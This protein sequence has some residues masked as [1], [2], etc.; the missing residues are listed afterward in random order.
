MILKND[1]WFWED[2]EIFDNAKDYIPSKSA[3]MAADVAY[4]CVKS[5]KQ[6][7]AGEWVWNTAKCTDTASAAVCEIMRIDGREIYLGTNAFR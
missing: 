3:D 6:Q 1:K 4:G 5:S 7:L 2:G